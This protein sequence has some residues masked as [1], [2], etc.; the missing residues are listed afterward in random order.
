MAKKRRK[1][2]KRKGDVFSLRSHWNAALGYVKESRKEI[3]F[4]ILLFFLSALIGFFFSERF[5]FLNALLRELVDLTSGLN[6][7]ELIFFILQNNVQ[8]ALVSLVFGIFFGIFPIINGV[9]NGIVLGYV[10]A[11]TSELVGFGEFWRILPHGIFELGAIFISLG[12]GLRLGGFV[13]AK[14]KVKELKRRFFE[15]INVFLLIVLPLLILAAI[16]EGLLIALI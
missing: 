1:S 2:S 4:M 16:I 3:Y 14:Q 15:S 8:S 7:L 12:M 10:L 9:L 6:A 11:I 5:T 13:F